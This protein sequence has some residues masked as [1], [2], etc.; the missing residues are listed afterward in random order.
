MKAV[1]IRDDD[2]NALTSP[3]VLERLYRPFLD[4]GMPICLATIPEVRLDTRGP[5][6][7]LEGFLMGDEAGQPAARA[8]GEDPR[9]CSYLLSEPGYAIVQHG[10]RHEY[11]DGFYEFDRNDGVDVGMRLDDGSRIL[12]AAG[13][14]PISAFV[15][16]QDRMS[17]LAMQEVMQRFRVISTGYYDLR[18]L[19]RSL[20]PGYLLAKKARKQA[21]FRSLRNTFLTHPGCILSHRRPLEGMLDSLID[22]VRQRSL[23]VIVSH[24]WEYFRDGQPN[25]PFIEVLHGLAEYLAASAEVK[26][27]KL[28]EARPWVR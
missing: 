21:H 6:G 8:I 14:H 26:V 20:W 16:P 19:P 17:R 9:L 28:D 24:H 15:A 11:V 10:L 7:K 18:K 2:T 27:I 1:I 12:K 23:T 3:G 13:L 5:D 4:R 22:Q 25:E